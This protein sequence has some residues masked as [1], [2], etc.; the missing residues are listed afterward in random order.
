MLR[1]VE[2]RASPPAANPGRR[3]AQHELRHL[4]EELSPPARFAPPDDDARA[5]SRSQ[6]ER[7]LERGAH[8]ESRVGEAVDEKTRS[9]VPGQPCPG[10]ASPDR[11]VLQVPVLVRNPTRGQAGSRAPRKRPKDGAAGAQR[12][13][14]DEREL[15]KAHPTGI[16]IA[17]HCCVEELDLHR[18][19]IAAAVVHQVVEGRPQAEVDE[20]LT[21]A[22]AAAQP[23]ERGVVSLVGA[24]RRHF[25]LPFGVGA[26]RNV[27]QVTPGDEDPERE[28][29]GRRVAHVARQVRI[30]EL[31]VGDLEDASVARARELLERLVGGVQAALDDLPHPTLVAV[32]ETAE[33][34]AQLRRRRGPIARARDEAGPLREP[35]H[36]IDRNHGAV[37]AGAGTEPRDAGIEKAQQLVGAVPREEVVRKLGALQLP[38]VHE[39]ELA[40]TLVEV[41]VVLPDVAVLPVRVPLELLVVGSDSER[42]GIPSRHALGEVDDA[43]VVAGLGSEVHRPAQDLVGLRSTCHVDPQQGVSEHGG[44]VVHE[45]LHE[46][47]RQP[48]D[49][50]ARAPALVCFA[51]RRGQGRF[52]DAE[53]IRQP[54]PAGYEDALRTL[55]ARSARVGIEQ[56][57]QRGVQLGSGIPVAVLAPSRPPPPSSGAARAT[58]GH[59]AATVDPR[60]SSSSA[61]RSARRWLGGACRVDSH[62]RRREGEERCGKPPEPAQLST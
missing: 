35:A 58:A 54:V 21:V 45:P 30:A 53:P 17:T 14:L 39:Q 61:R 27:A 18:L 44:G 1:E 57:A 4:A 9:R 62:A 15:L 42:G 10:P 48:A 32:R 36:G 46:D 60:S 23:D 41:E 29:A 37:K 20:G 56:G 6:T 2:S 38:E 55:V 26:G 11:R 33:G 28:A 25:D 31:F 40:L 51:V 16:G 49:V 59:R 5:C 47:E 12:L 22:P 7:I 19:R 43:V 52:V 34:R 24:D 3:V 50:E 8:V 13:E